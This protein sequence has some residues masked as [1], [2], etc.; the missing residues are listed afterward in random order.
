MSR[1]GHVDQT[2]PDEFGYGLGPPTGVLVLRYPPLGAGTHFPEGRDD[3]RHRLFWSPDGILAVRRG[4]RITHL[5][6][7]DAFWVRRGTDVEVSGSQ[8]QAV[9]VLCLRE[10]P[11]RLSSIPGASVP[12]DESARN[13]V[14]ALCRRRVT[15]DDGLELRAILLAGLGTPIP[16]EHSALGS[17]LARRVAASVMADPGDPADLTQWAARLHTSTKTLQRDFLREYGEPWSTWRTRM[18]LHAS[19]ALLDRRPVS[20]VAHRV[21]YASASAY[22]AAFRREFGETPGRRAA[23]VR[24]GS[25]GPPA[26]A[27]P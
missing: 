7:H 1:T 17:G 23:R 20:E 19:L 27:R 24:R 16:L 26:R 6:P 2:V 22:V 25:S 4:A 13:A 8:H 18:R 5:G 11:V 10:A 14:L 9:H 12:M 15:E 21:G 3:Y